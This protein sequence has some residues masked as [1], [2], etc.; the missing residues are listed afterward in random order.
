MTDG[1]QYVPLSQ[2]KLNTAD[3]ISDEEVQ[4]IINKL[5]FEGKFL[6]RHMMASEMKAY[7]DGYIDGCKRM[8]DEP[9][10]L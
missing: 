3:I 7:N 8:M 9:K 1:S 10:P 2:R 4:F 5:G 6:A